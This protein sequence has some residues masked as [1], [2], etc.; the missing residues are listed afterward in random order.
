[1][2]NKLESMLNS[3]SPIVVSGAKLDEPLE[4]NHANIRATGGD[5]IELKTLTNGH[6]GHSGS[7]E[8]PK[9]ELHNGGKF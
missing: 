1:M 4:V 2:K 7:E 8:E 9:R 3:P 6:S 5:T